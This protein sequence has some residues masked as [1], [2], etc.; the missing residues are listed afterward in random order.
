MIYPGLKRDILTEL[1]RIA[2]Q[3]DLIRK[4]LAKNFRKCQNM[5]FII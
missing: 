4:K 3:Q 2:K 1:Y 5:Y